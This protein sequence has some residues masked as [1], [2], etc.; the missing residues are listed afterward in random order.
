M[1]LTLEIGWDSDSPVTKRELW[2]WRYMIRDEVRIKMICLPAI[3]AAEETNSFWIEIILEFWQIFIH[4]VCHW[5]K[6][7]G[8]NRGLCL[9]T[10]KIIEKKSKTKV[11]YYSYY[12]RTL[13]QIWLFYLRE[14]WKIPEVHRNNYSRNADN[15]IKNSIFEF[16][17]SLDTAEQR[18][19]ELER[20]TN[21]NSDWST[22]RQKDK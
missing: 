16:N 19:H 14:Y 8:R 2:K 10:R 9:K 3:Y 4:N 5:I 11:I 21:K 1:S 7:Y 20:L 22:K 18:I 17:S 13:E 6:H 15:K 12:T